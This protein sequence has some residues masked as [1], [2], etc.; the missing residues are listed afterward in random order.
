M[1]LQNSK[2]VHT[3]IQKEAEGAIRRAPKTIIN[4]VHAKSIRA[5]S[6]ALPIGAGEGAGRYY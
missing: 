4:R 2:C 5:V 3:L 6:S 1:T